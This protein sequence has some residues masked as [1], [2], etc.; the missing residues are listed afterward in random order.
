MSSPSSAYSGCESE[1][2][3]FEYPFIKDLK[4]LSDNKKQIIAI[5]KKQEVKLKKVCRMTTTNLWKTLKR[6]VL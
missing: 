3:E 6:E 1:K 2:A 5:A 4:L